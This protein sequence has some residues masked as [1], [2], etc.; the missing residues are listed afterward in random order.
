MTRLPRR[1]SK[2]SKTRCGYCS[3]TVEDECEAM[4]CRRTTLW[5]VKKTVGPCGKC[6][7]MSASTKADGRTRVGCQHRIRSEKS[8]S[9]WKKVAAERRTGY[10]PVLVDDDEVGDLVGPAGVGEL[11]DDIVSAVDAVRV[12]Q[13]EPHLLGELEQLGRRIAR[14]RQENLW[15]V[16]AR[17]RV[18]VIDVVG[19][20]CA[21]SR[22][23]ARETWVISVRALVN[24]RRP[25]LD[26]GLTG[27]G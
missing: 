17:P 3:E 14:G 22:Q 1:D 10:A 24:R 11:L 27:P 15:V 20:V 8:I 26:A 4:S 2:P 23:G 9:R 6:E 16:D 25:P 5:S 12:G 13:D 19:R 7:T 21:W 18:L